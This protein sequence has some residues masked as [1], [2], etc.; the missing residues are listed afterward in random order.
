MFGRIFGKLLVF[1][2]GKK[3]R[4]TL[5]RKAETICLTAFK[6]ESPIS[7]GLV[8]SQVP[9]LAALGSRYSSLK[10]QEIVPFQELTHIINLL[11]SISSPYLIVEISPSVLRLQ[12]ISSPLEFEIRF[13]YSTEEKCLT[14]RISHNAAYCGDGWFANED[15]YWRLAEDVKPFERWIKVE[16]YEGQKIVELL[17]SVIPE[18][19]KHQIPLTSSL[20][21][22]K[23][24]A[25]SI[26][27][28]D[29]TEMQ[30]R[31]EI[32]WMV[33]PSSM[34]SIPSLP[35]YL[36]CQNMIRPG[37]S[38]K[39][40]GLDTLIQKPIITFTGEQIP[41]FIFNLWPQVASFSKG[42]CAELLQ[43]HSIL[44]QSGLIKVLVQ[45]ELSDGIGIIKAVPTFVAD[46]LSI[47]AIT[48][49]KLLGSS[50]R[51]IRI[52]EGWL[53]TAIVKS[54]GIELNSRTKD[55]TPLA[56]STLSPSEILQHDLDRFADPS[57]KVECPEINI[58][59]G[60]NIAETAGL[61]LE[62]LRIWGIPGGLVGEVNSLQPAFIS[63]C[64]NLFSAAP[65]SRILLIGTKRTLDLLPSDLESVPVQRYYGLRNDPEFSSSIS[66]LV[67]ATPKGIETNP[68]LASVHWTVLSLLELDIL[69]KTGNSRLFESLITLSRSLTIASFNSV[70][71]MDRRAQREAINSVFRFASRRDAD[72]I[73]KYCLRNPQQPPEQPQS[74]MARAVEPIALP[75]FT[76]GEPHANSGIPIPTR[77]T[78]LPKPVHQIAINVQ[79]RISAPS[80]SFLQ[81]ARKFESTRNGICPF[82]PFM[83]YWPTYSSLTE[84]QKQWYFYW[85]DQVRNS[86]HPE[87]SLSYIFLHIYEL[88]HGVGAPNA[89]AA[90][91]QLY[92][93]W[94][95]YRTVFPKLDSYLPDWIVDFS[96]MYKLQV[97]ILKPYLD[98]ISSGN[99]ECADLLVSLHFNDELPKVPVNLLN[100]YSDY[101][102]DRSKFYT[103]GNS[104]F[105]CE[106]LSKVIT[107][108]DTYFKSKTS[109]GI[110]NTFQP[111]GS[112][113][114]RRDPFRSA[115]Y[116]G[117][118]AQI[119]L[120]S[121]YPYS[122]HPP[123]REFMT[124]VTKHTENCL[125]QI[126]QFR[127]RLR[128]I[129]LPDD[130]REI[131]DELLVG[132][133]KPE[134]SAPIKVSLDFS[135]VQDL[136]VE[137]NSVRELLLTTVQETHQMFTLPNN[138][139]L[140]KIPRP[141]G[142]SDH[143]LTDLDP[144]W[145]VLTRL[146]ANET[147]MLVF[148][149]G[150]GWH[151]DTNMLQ[152]AMP[153]TLVETAIEH[154]NE[155]SLKYAG[156]LLI[157]AESETKI[158]AEDYRDEL[159]Y[160]LLHYQPE[161]IDKP[162]QPLQITG[163]PPEWVEL[164]K[165]MGKHHLAALR[166]ILIGANR[167]ELAKIAEENATMPES[168]VESINEIALDAIGDVI[169][170]PGSD[171]PVIEDEDL[172]MV[173]RLTSISN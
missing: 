117:P 46:S 37:I 64:Q 38:P 30:V 39:D 165:R 68:G 40:F 17:S 98:S 4:L 15:A 12:P 162:S 21:F 113:D 52:S 14:R 131:I 51:F 91:E 107:H 84:P 54:A 47:P 66:G 67:L 114:I 124:A 111:R 156:D 138:S 159:E 154:I 152:H 95:A 72:A 60:S 101:R 78:S 61:H 127:T 3:Y 144:I 86:H 82:I 7:L 65:S 122:E 50:N 118:A 109:K 80:D 73:W 10:P 19:T 45:R 56:I 77:S 143:L 83:C 24:P 163:I 34:L 94:M 26:S 141:I 105:V 148:M 8:I 25:L 112:I 97:P 9:Q 35:G 121:V 160:L 128:G 43:T 5:S 130:I 103:A 89:Q 76:V 42:K 133:P 33:E 146:D 62:F 48:I 53:P 151:A 120:G 90:Y 135:K 74:S 29:V 36:L 102:F 157:A 116:S 104:D 170:A 71:F 169:I 63:M 115:V 6:G 140:P 136:I 20:S 41:E 168:L 119:Q 147:K 110:L 69:V 134:T 70:E 142:T 1:I 92:A 149:L 150:E 16:R 79:V 11:C 85:R 173:K 108:I 23:D 167:S 171:P 137:S 88:I 93:I 125:R 28:A 153:E 145:A 75:E 123:L 81:E 87:T 57:M 129:T 126:R 166:I 49:S 13:D 155:L 27:I 55:W 59:S 139:E 96:I 31:M 44:S 161:P 32:E 58:P 2:S 22:I 172:E 158:I 106:N 18:A 132:Q 99:R 164:L 100:C